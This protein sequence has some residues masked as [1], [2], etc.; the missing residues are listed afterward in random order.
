MKIL[1]L[2]TYP[3]RHSELDPDKC[4]DRFQLIAFSVCK[5]LKQE[6][7]D[8]VYESSYYPVNSW[9][10]PKKVDHTI[11]IENHGFYQRTLKF[12]QV[13]ESVTSGLVCNI[14]SDNK[15]CSINNTLFYLNPLYPP[16]NKIM[17][18]LKWPCDD[19]LYK[20]TKGDVISILSN[21][22]S[23]NPKINEYM[24]D[25]P[26]TIDKLIKYTKY[27]KVNGA[28]I[29][30]INKKI[31]DY[32]T[33]YELGMANVVIVAK[34]KLVDRRI[35]DELS[36]IVYKDFNEVVWK[37]AINNIDDIHTRDKLIK[38]NY[39]WKYGVKKITDVLMKHVSNKKKT[40]KKPKNVPIKRSL[41]NPVI[42]QSQLNTNAIII[43][44]DKDN[45]PLEYME[46]IESLQEN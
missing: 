9:K 35:V 31:T 39:T 25:T 42:I 24:V 21:D 4:R 34:D 11:L 1:I 33:L 27:T 10:L 15:Y 5:Y 6:G 20:P 17:Y 29:C 37:T 18:P 46:Y 36:I 43:T 26:H 23:I 38:L 16:Y 32:C 30:V 45:P 44:I 12:S 40:I 7:I 14:S 28:H 2:T 3:I 19:E 22:T 8:L 13:L 41:K